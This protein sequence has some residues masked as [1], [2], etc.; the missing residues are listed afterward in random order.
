MPAFRGLDGEELVREHLT[1][2][3]GVLRGNPAASL[4]QARDSMGLA[5][6]FRAADASVEAYLPEYRPLHV[7]VLRTQAASRTD[8][9]RAGGAGRR[10]RIEA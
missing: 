2:L 5:G 10:G 6:G 9:A 4:E 7:G 1:S 3:P 8:R